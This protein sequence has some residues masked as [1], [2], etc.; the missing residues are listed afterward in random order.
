MSFVSS[1]IRNSLLSKVTAAADL[2]CVMQ[3]IRRVTNCR[4]YNPNLLMFKSNLEFLSCSAVT[5]W[6]R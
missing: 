3:N 1:F 6:A 5:L 4:V 2:P